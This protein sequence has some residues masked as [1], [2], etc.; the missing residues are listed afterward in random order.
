MTGGRKMK[1]NYVKSQSSVAPDLIDT[2]SSK[3]SVYIRRNITE[4]TQDEDSVLYEY[5]EA[6]L[7]KED[8]EKYLEELSLMDIQQLR[9][10]LDYL[11]LM[12]GVSL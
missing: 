5:E 3:Y 12:T 6:K 1:F 10:D 9:A 11:S 2:D 7:S 8:Y 4:I